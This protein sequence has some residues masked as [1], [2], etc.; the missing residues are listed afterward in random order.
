MKPS[1][2]CGEVTWNRQGGGGEEGEDSADPCLPSGPH[3]ALLS[4]RFGHSGS[5]V[6]FLQR[7]LPRP[8]IGWPITGIVSETGSRSG[9]AGT[10][11]RV[12]RA[13]GHGKGLGVAR[14]EFRLSVTFIGRMILDKSLNILCVKFASPSPLIPRIGK[15]GLGV[16]GSGLGS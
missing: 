10:R 9:W 3:S 11:S 7:Q 1:I 13:Q 16:R 12:L 8:G 5:A 14:A 15:R 2:L 6:L 4:G